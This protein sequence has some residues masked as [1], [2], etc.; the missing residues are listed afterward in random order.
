MVF[1]RILDFTNEAG[2]LSGLFFIADFAD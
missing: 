1:H 2:F